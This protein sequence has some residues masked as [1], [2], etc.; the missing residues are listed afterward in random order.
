M[1]PFIVIGA[2]LLLAGARFSVPAGAQ[3]VTSVHTMEVPARGPVVI[4]RFITAGEGGVEFPEADTIDRVCVAFHNTDPRPATAVHLQLVFFDGGGTRTGSKVLTRTGTFSTGARVAAA[5]DHRTHPEDCLPIK[6]P[7]G[8]QIVIAYY[9]D[10][11]DFADGTSWNATGLVFPDRAVPGLMQPDVPAPKTIAAG[12]TLAPVV[13]RTAATCESATVPAIP[14]VQSVRVL[15]QPGAPLGEGLFRIGDVATCPGA[16][17]GSGDAAALAA[18]K[19]YPVAIVGPQMFQVEVPALAVSATCSMPPRLLSRV[20]LNTRDESWEGRG[21]LAPVGDYT[22]N[23]HVTVRADGFPTNPKLTRSTG[24]EEYDFALK[25]SAM[26]SRFW[27]ALDNGAPV[28]GDFD[29]A[30]RWSIVPGPVSGFTVRVYGA[31]L[32]PLAAGCAP[33]S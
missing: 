1:R 29:F 23:V 19:Q 28:T 22:G 20:L 2:V 8:E 15:A 10:R 9:I 17:A 30:M 11:V 32:T 31:A 7:T 27:P 25:Y 21:R 26:E 5:D 18:V 16:A 12:A 4:D 14:A 33:A 13:T 3:E 6:V 24:R